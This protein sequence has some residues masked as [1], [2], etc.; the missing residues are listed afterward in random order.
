M[1][2]ETSDKNAKYKRKRLALGGRI[3]EKKKKMVLFQKWCEAS[4]L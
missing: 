2:P 3:T 4:A 1:S